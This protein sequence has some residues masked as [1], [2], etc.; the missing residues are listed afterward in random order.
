MELS[1]EF[2]AP[3]IKYL[4]CLTHSFYPGVLWVTHK[5]EFDKF[6]TFN[7]GITFDSWQFWFL[8][9]KMMATSFRRFPL[10]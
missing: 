3:E 8:D 9:G 10:S 1:C 7:T 5:K 6:L 2:T 4:G